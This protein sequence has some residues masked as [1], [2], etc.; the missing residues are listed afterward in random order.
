MRAQLKQQRTPA[1][2]TARLCEARCL[3]GCCSGS[4]HAPVACVA[5]PHANI[6]HKQRRARLPD[7]ADAQGQIHLMEMSSRNA[8][9]TCFEPRPSHFP[10]LIDPEGNPLRRARSG[11]SGRDPQLSP[12]TMQDLIAYNSDFPSLAQRL[13]HPSSHLI[14]HRGGNQTSLDL[15]VLVRAWTPVRFSCRFHAAYASAP[16]SC[17]RVSSWQKNE[18]AH[19]PIPAAYLIRLVAQSKSSRERYITK[20]ILTRIAR[21]IGRR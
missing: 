8:A 21:V 9:S 16:R 18:I 12:H 7:F 20:R 19:S 5:E 13:R 4:S 11:K 10:T 15:G 17:H 6:S 2:L 1:D 3:L 14:T